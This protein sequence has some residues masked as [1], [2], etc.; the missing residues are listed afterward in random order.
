MMLNQRAELPSF[1]E[2][3]YWLAEPQPGL[4]EMVYRHEA[5]PDPQYLFAQTPLAGLQ[6]HG[7][8]LISL[9]AQSSLLGYLRNAPA[10]FQG[11]LLITPAE[12][13]VVLAHLQTLLEVGFDSQRR[14]LL[15]Y[16]DPLVASYFW[17]SI[18]ADETATWMGSIQ[19]IFWYGG[20]WAN[21]AER[22]LQWYELT[23]PQQAKPSIHTGHHVLSAKQQQALINQ[24][25]EQF[26]FD[27]LQVNPPVPFPELMGQIHAGIT[28]GYEDKTSLTAWLD[29][30]NRY[31]M[32]RQG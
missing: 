13:S 17:P 27:W 25:I 20:T 28:A 16:Y 9:A 19:Q 24:S 21:K 26:A 3:T 1:A 2:T 5:E 30:Q 18:E 7:P 6:E 11:L 15:R 12:R 32:E 14:A 4:L 8:V 22:K 10:R 31:K 23:Q 29:D